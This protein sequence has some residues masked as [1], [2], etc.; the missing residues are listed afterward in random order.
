[1]VVINH[2]CEMSSESQ[3]CVDQLIV[4]VNEIDKL[5]EL[6]DSK[7]DVSDIRE[8]ARQKLSTTQAYL[9]NNRHSIPSYTLKKVTD[10]LKKLERRIDRPQKQD[11]QFRFKSKPIEH[12]IIEQKGQDIKME[13]TPSKPEPKQFTLPEEINFCG[14]KDR[15]K[16]SMSLDSS[17]VHGKDISLINLEACEI[18]IKGSA[19]T[20]RLRDLKG[21]T[22]TI[23]LAIRSITVINCSECIFKL[24]CQ[25]LRINAA[26]SCQFELFTSARSM[27]EES[28][29]LTFKCLDMDTLKPWLN[30]EERKEYFDNA[31]FNIDR[32]NWNCIDD[33]EWLSPSIPSKNFTLVQ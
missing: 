5:L 15:S 21:C 18:L 25:Q 23:I 12:D 26:K 4:T 29:G 14:F 6:F 11:F 1:M 16:E 3:K 19:E 7:Q 9:E 2:I 33:F 27:M 22:V 20:A 32:N 17:D 31:K 30:E 28:S 10:S 24:C 13:V 8:I